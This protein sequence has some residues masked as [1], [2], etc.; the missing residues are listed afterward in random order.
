MRRLVFSLSQPLFWCWSFVF[1]WA[2][3][4][5]VTLLLQRWDGLAISLL[6]LLAAHM[7]A[8]TV[9]RRRNKNLRLESSFGIN[10]NN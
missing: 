4:T 8:I 5:V 1:I 7:V 3:H 6:G 2:V 9:Q 10:L